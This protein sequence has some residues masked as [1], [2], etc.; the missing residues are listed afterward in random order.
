MGLCDITRFSQLHFVEPDTDAMH[1]I[2]MQLYVLGMYNDLGD[3]IPYKELCYRALVH[4]LDETVCCDIPRNIKYHSD[5][6]FKL[7]NGIT[8]HLLHESGVRK[9]L[10]DDIESAK[11]KDEWGYII[12][13]LDIYDAFCTLTKEWKLQN[14]DL[15][16]ER[17]KESAGYLRDVLDKIF[18]SD[19]PEGVKLYLDKET[20]ELLKEV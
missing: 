14:R 15:L 18:N 5:E 9:E 12:K 7:I 20:K 10:I 6:A 16:H 13:Y 4:D 1:T 17:M 3:E 19:I 2:R 11:S 8:T